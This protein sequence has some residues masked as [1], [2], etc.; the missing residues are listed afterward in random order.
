MYSLLHFFKC[1]RDIDGVDIDG[2]ASVGV[3]AL[4]KHPFA[5]RCFSINDCE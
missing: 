3:G 4:V 5:Y 2:E 1:V